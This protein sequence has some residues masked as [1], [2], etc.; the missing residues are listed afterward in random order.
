MVHAATYVENN[1][2]SEVEVNSCSKDKGKNV[3]FMECFYDK[4]H[5]SLQITNGFYLVRS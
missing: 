3:F 5:L 2:G 4:L 1:I